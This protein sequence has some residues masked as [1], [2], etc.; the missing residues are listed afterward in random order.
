VTAFAAGGSHVEAI[1]A[2]EAVLRPALGPRLQVARPLAPLTSF[3]IGG[4]AALFAE[5][6]GEPDLEAIAG[7]MS[8]SGIEWT[9]LGKGSNVLISDA[10]FQGLVLRLGR[11][12]VW[13]ERDGARVR[14][15]AATPL[16]RVSG[17]AA[18][19]GLTGLE[20]GV[21]IPGSLGGAVRMNAGAHGRSMSDVVESVRA[22]SFSTA[23]TTTVRAEDAGFAYRT[24]AFGRGTLV[25]E[26]SMA[27]RDADPRSIRERMDEARAWR[28]ATQPLAEPNCGSV[29][30]NP[31][32]GHAAR[33]VDEAGCKGLGHGGARVSTKHANFIVTR[34]GATAVDVLAVIE[35]V[36]DRVR[37]RFGVE[38]ET[39]V[40]LVGDHD[41]AHR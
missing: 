33:L 29:F 24:S 12:H 17:A 36:R 4:P 26:A 11:A 34:P 18:A 20:F 27:L 21:A 38:L 41:A 7:A 2:A 8:A 15:G 19:A 10:G 30:K 14:S 5:P 13:T 23:A 35:D 37:D 6:D 32:G 25:L 39:E 3:R 31:P 28:R 40:Q 16:P 9:I 1:A 22:F